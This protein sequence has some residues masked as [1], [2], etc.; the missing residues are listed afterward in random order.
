[1]LMSSL[2]LMCSKSFIIEVISPSRL[3]PDGLN[4]RQS[5]DDSSYF[6]LGY[7]MKVKAVFESEMFWTCG[8]VL[9]MPSNFFSSFYLQKYFGLF[10]LGSESSFSCFFTS[11]VFYLSSP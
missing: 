2:S 10:A 3:S 5:A 1:M 7:L 6:A 11:R 9:L 8:S 4:G